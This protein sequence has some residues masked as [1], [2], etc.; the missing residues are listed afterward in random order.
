[1]SLWKFTWPGPS[2]GKQ[3]KGAEKI[4]LSAEAQKV[5][6][7]ISDPLVSNEEAH[8]E[9]NALLGAWE[10][11][12]RPPVG[13]SKTEKK[14]IRGKRIMTLTQYESGLIDIHITRAETP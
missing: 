2:T 3:E 5:W 10:N 8:D 6:D 9:V 7:K 14:T 11:R 13:E 4:I 1:M 12:G